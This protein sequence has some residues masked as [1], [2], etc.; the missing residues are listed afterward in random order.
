MTTTDN[1]LSNKG[2]F[3]S[4][5]SNI[6]K[7]KKMKEWIKQTEFILLYGKI[8]MSNNYNATS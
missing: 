5:L 3:E 4:F 6:L 8:Y 1:E 7:M 2:T